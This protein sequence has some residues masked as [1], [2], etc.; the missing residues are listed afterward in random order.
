MHKN[1]NRSL[2]NRDIFRNNTYITKIRTKNR[3]RM[4][5]YTRPRLSIPRNISHAAKRRASWDSADSRLPAHFLLP[6]HPGARPRPFGARQRRLRRRPCYAPHNTG[7]RP[8][9]MRLPDLSVIIIVTR[10]IHIQQRVK[11]IR[12]FGIAVPFKILLIKPNRT[13]LR[14]RYSLKRIEIRL[15][16]GALVSR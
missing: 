3:G 14:N 6:S 4:C 11:P 2:Q 7:V 16:V 1:V 15:L 5:F 13:F 10:A 9:H 8:R 12:N